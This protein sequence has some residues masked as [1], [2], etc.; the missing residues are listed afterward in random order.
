MNTLL[1]TN[2][3][4]R[5]AQPGHPMHTTAVDAVDALRRRGDMLFIVPQIFY[6]F[7][8]VGTRPIAQNGLGFTPA[9]TRTEFDQFKKFFT[10]LEE[11][12][13][14]FPAVGTTRDELC[15]V[16]EERT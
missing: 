9:Q 6:E 4:T 13:T 1:D 10:P 7:W 11:T 15:S 5:T 8:V 3:L 12:P 2:I 14:V 16:G